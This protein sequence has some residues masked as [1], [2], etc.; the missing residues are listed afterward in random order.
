MLDPPSWFRV[1]L[2]A[3]LPRIL[4]YPIHRLLSVRLRLLGD[5]CL[6][7]LLSRALLSA[8]ADQLTQCGPL[9]CAS[10]LARSN[11]YQRRRGGVHTASSMAAHS[12]DS[13]PLLHKDGGHPSFPS[14]LRLLVVD[15]DP[16]CLMIVAGMLRK[17]NYE[18]AFARTPCRVVQHDSQTIALAVSVYAVVCSRCAT[19]QPTCAP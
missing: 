3:T 2:I 5:F 14:G 7:R 8:S 13:Q 16:T 11:H 15:D 19:M 10:H 1:C 9:I 17:C 12:A 4:A 18:G 6:C